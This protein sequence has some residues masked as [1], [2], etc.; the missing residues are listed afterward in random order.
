MAEI[1]LDD[2][3]DRLIA[4]A[5]SL[6]TEHIGFEW[7]FKEEL[8]GLFETLFKIKFMLHD[9]QKRQ[10]FDESMRNYLM[11]LRDVAYGRR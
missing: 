9:A 7:G 6:A 3:V 5:F 11:E 2:I 1:V 8:G 10:V 4:N